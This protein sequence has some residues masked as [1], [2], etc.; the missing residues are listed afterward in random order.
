MP[1]RCLVAALLAVSSVSAFA[2]LP[3]PGI[4]GQAHYNRGPTF[5]SSTFETLSIDLPGGKV[6]LTTMGEPAPAIVAD[7]SVDA[8]DSAFLFGRAV[9]IVRYSMQV[10]GPVGPVAVDIDASGAVS[11]SASA[12]ATFVVEA[13]WSL[14]DPSFAE[15]VSRSADSGGA[16]SGSFSR[17]FGGTVAVTLQTGSIYTVELRADAQ[18]AATAEDSKADSHAQIDPVFSLGAG[19]DPDVYSFE[20]SPGIG[21]TAAVP[22]PAPWALFAGG[23]A[24]GAARFRRRWRSAP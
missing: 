20:F 24:L 14:F 18:S 7:A 3:N 17:A 1:T 15:I 2:A 11:A 16:M 22:E 12:G 6:S 4:I 23:I 5:D 13:K 8:A 19:V 10:L 9:A 21:N